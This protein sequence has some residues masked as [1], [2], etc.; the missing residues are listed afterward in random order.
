MFRGIFIFRFKVMLSNGA[1]YVGGALDRALLQK[2]ISYF[3][4]FHCAAL[5]P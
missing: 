3:L 2:K 5:V 4:H 1:T